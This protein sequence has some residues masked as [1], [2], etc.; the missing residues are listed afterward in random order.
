MG[1]LARVRLPGRFFGSNKK[2]GYICVHVPHKSCLKC[3]IRTSH[4]PSG[5]HH[6]TSQRLLT[7]TRHQTIRPHTRPNSHRT[8]RLHTAF[9]KHTNGHDPPLTPLLVL[10]H[11]VPGTYMSAGHAVTTVTQKQKEGYDNQTKLPR[12][13]APLSLICKPASSLSF[14][15]T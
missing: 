13:L 12:R 11:S 5:R 7:A 10:T 8:H 3:V 6:P 1:W 2:T 15:Q 4:H 9:S 14:T